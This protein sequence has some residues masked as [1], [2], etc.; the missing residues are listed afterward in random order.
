MIQNLFFEQKV[1]CLQKIN[2][3]KSSHLRDEQSI[4]EIKKIIM[5]E[6]M[7]QT[8]MKKKNTKKTVTKLSIWSQ[9]ISAKHN[10]TMEQALVFY[11]SVL[12]F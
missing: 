3:K 9:K 8:L 10:G 4:K 12:K 5:S 1:Q 11:C 7:F 6:Q 2:Q